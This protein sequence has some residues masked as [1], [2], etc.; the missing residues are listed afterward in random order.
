MLSGTNLD[1]CAEIVM[2]CSSEGGRIE[3]QKEL[4]LL[5]ED[6]DKRS[7]IFA[8][9]DRLLKLLD[10]YIEQNFSQISN[11][12]PILDFL[13]NQEKKFFKEATGQDE[14]VDS[15]YEIIS[16]IDLLNTRNL[17]ET[18]DRALAWKESLIGIAADDLQ[19]EMLCVMAARIYAALM[20]KE[21]QL[22]IAESQSGAIGHATQL[23][24]GVGQMVDVFR[25]VEA[26]KRGSEIETKYDPSD[27]PVWKPTRKDIASLE[28]IRRAVECAAGLPSLEDGKVRK[29]TT[30]EVP[31]PDSAVDSVHVQKPTG[32]GE[33]RR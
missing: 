2:R 19:K 17:L 23:N 15:F 14:M 21:E 30:M 12:A 27:M 28:R 29:W 10:G 3:L 6:S 32:R 8:S 1:I 18:K 25:G 33:W 9:N 13:R 11:L 20:R 5:L 26:A 4:K 22:A 31:F 16:S 7:Q 24:I